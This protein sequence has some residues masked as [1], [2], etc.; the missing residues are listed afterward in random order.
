[1]DSLVYQ[2]VDLQAA[3]KLEPNDKSKSLGLMKC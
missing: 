1:M 2:Q 3:A